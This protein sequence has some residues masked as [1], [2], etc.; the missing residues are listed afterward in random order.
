VLAV[1]LLGG[2]VVLFGGMPSWLTAS[3][4]SRTNS[5]ADIPAPSPAGLDSRAP[6]P[7]NEEIL[8]RIAQHIFRIQA[9]QESLRDLPLSQRM[10]AS[11]SKSDLDDAGKYISMLLA[12]N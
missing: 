3:D 1:L 9:E 6:T 5:P 4:Q 7:L 2:F 8:R 12:L 11:L 10:I